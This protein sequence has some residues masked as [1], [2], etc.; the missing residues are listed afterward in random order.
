MNQIEENVACNSDYYNNIIEKNPNF[1]NVIRSI[2]DELQ[3]NVDPKHNK[4]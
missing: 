2:V 4:T 3:F 1:G